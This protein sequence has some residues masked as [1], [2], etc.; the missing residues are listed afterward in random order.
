MAVQPHKIVGGIINMV[1]MSAKNIGLR[2]RAWREWVR[3]LRARD[4]Y[5]S[6]PAQ[7]P[8]PTHENG[9]I[10]LQVWDTFRAVIFVSNGS[11]NVLRVE[12]VP[13]RKRHG[14]GKWPEKNWSDIRECKE[15]TGYGCK[16][17][18]GRAILGNFYGDYKQSHLRK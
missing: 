11:V 10:Y 2:L 8:H 18:R 5:P 16:E 9:Q 14:D 1:I 3:S 12:D 13:S 17:P 15:C 4:S 7:L 6:Y